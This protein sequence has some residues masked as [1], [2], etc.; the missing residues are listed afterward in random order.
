MSK[1]FFLFLF[2]FVLFETAVAKPIIDC[3]VVIGDTTECNPYGSKLLQTKEVVYDLDR[4]KLIRVKTLPVPEKKRFMR[5][6]S[7]QEMV[8]KYVTIEDSKRFKGSDISPF[9]SSELKEELEVKTKELEV[10]EVDPVIKQEVLEKTAPE[11]PQITY[12]HYRVVRGD[13]LSK[14]ARKF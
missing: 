8:D 13:A 7:V 6:V 12:G 1:K 5:V 4:K 9:K 2:S 10:C 3:R 14:L 11:Q